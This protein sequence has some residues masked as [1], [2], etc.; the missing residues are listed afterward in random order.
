MGQRN[1][2][3]FMA[4]GVHDVLWAVYGF[5]PKGNMLITAV[6]VFGAICI[7]YYIWK[8]LRCC[9]EEEVQ[10]NLVW[11][12][13][14]AHITPGIL[15]FYFSDRENNLVVLS[16]ACALFRGLVALV[17]FFKIVSIYIIPNLAHVKD[18]YSRT[19]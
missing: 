5:F 3:L 2:N 10:W 14:G 4:V 11:P 15:I 8:F 13:S 12:I 7:I 18:S 6:N 9:D 16:W 1:S 19:D 17:T